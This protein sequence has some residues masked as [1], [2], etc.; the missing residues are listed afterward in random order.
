MAEDVKASSQAPAEVKTDAQAPATVGNQTQG[1]A[2]ATA[3][4]ETP[5]KPSQSWMQDP[6]FQRTLNSH[7]SK[8]E[9]EWQKKFEERDREYTR[10]LEQMKFPPHQDTQDPLAGLSAEQRA[11]IEELKKHIGGPYEQ[12]MK[13]LRAELEELR[14]SSTQSAVDAELEQ[15]SKTYGEKY[16]MNPQEVK[17]ML[18]EFADNDPFFADKDY[19]RGFWTAA[20]RAAF[21][22]KAQEIADRNAYQ[23]L[24]AEKEKHQKVG[25]QNPSGTGQAT[26]RKYA[27]MHEQLKVRAEEM[28]SKGESLF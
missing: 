24:Q 5:S 2:P 10:R 17:D 14:S 26:P 11:G 28:R 3:Q 23:R 15:V 13:E 20:S 18:L 27:D 25:T 9:R 6:E 16:Q 8:K 12:A 22:D 21:V 1:T 7:L 19:R 4:A